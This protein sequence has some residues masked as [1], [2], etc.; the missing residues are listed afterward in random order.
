MDVV[1]FKQQITID[2]ARKNKQISELKERLERKN[3]GLRQEE[4]KQIFESF[5]QQKLVM[6]RKIQEL[7]ED[8][9]SQSRQLKD[10]YTKHKYLKS[11][12]A[13]V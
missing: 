5:K 11:K 3:S 10:L 9:Q 7:S 2:L 4:K 6:Q 8:N 13:F 1:L 12:Y